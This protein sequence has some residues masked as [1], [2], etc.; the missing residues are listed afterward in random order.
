MQAVNG[1][2]PAIQSK[3]ALAGF[4]LSESQWTYQQIVCPVIPKHLL[5]L[6]SRNEGAGDTS[7]FS[8]ILPRNGSGVR[9][10]PILR[11][12]FAQ[13]TPAPENPL[14][15]ATFNR[16]RENNHTE[17]K[18]DWLMT[19]LC[20]AALTGSHVTLVPPDSD[21]AGSGVL[22]VMA[23][24]LQIDNGMNIVHFLDLEKVQ[25]PREWDL[26]FDSKGK[27]VKVAVTGYPALQM[28]MLP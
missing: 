8:V 20:Y 3:A 2:M 4:N 22:P 13:Y 16:L 18:P 14:S 1:A 7:L 23:P 26:T 10:L 9:V 24:A 27:L 12:S 6:Y 25:V 28:K 19:G 5:L 17:K 11:R 15:I 21:R